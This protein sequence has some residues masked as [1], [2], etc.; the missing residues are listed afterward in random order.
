[1]FQTHSVVSGK[2]PA[3]VT[4]APSINS[5]S[6]SI[7]SPDKEKIIPEKQE[8]SFYL[9]QTLRIGSSNVLAFLES[10]SNAHLIDEKVA[11]MEGL[12]KTSER[13]TAILMV[14]GGNIKSSMST[15]QFNLGPGVNGEFF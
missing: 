2:S 9:M 5:T 12:L 11:S 6:G 10:G 15:Y 3:I 14:G 7:E 8:D 13:P 1:M 4:L